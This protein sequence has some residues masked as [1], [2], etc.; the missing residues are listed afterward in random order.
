MD[1]QPLPPVLKDDENERPIPGAW[2]P[3][4]QAIVAAFVKGDYEMSVGVPGVEPLSPEKAQHVRDSIADYGETLVDLPD[5]TWKSSVTL[6]MGSHWDVLIDLW[7][8]SEGRSD[9][10]LDCKVRETEDGYRYQVHL[11]YVP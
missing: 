3:T 5:D 2:R 1:G 10:V 9:L 8:E 7:T 6:W 4:F 11:V